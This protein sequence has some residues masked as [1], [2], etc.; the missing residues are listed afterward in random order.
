[1]FNDAHVS[2]IFSGEYSPLDS[3]GH[4]QAPGLPHPATLEIILA[5]EAALAQVSCHKAVTKLL[6]NLSLLREEDS[7]KKKRRGEKTEKTSHSNS[8]SGV[9]TSE[10][11]KENDEKA[12]ESILQKKGF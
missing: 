11:S 2:S 6:C 12:G 1:M 3:G 8:D 10:S 5:A 4:Q 9:F 7:P